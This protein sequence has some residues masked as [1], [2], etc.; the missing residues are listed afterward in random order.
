M[1]NKGLMST[2]FVLPQALVSA[3]GLAGARRRKAAYPSALERTYHYQIA[4]SS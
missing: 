4:F 3:L 2:L 1:S